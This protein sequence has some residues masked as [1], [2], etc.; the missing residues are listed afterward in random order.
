MTKLF[1]VTILVKQVKKKNVPLVQ[2]KIFAQVAMMVIYYLKENAF[3]IILL[4]QLI[5]QVKIIKQ[6]N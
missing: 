6:L 5:L 2:K 4:E 1:L 3:Y